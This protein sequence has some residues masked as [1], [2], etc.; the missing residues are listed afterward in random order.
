MALF[1]PRYAAGNTSLKLL[2]Y[3][4]SSFNPCYTRGENKHKNATYVRPTLQPPLRAGNTCDLKAFKTDVAFNPRYTTRGEYGVPVSH[5]N[6][7]DLQPPC[8]VMGNKV[9]C[10]YREWR[11]TGSPAGSTLLA[12]SQPPNRAA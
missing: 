6:G 8:V 11:F 5:I 1:N 9:A 12:G 10:V 3:K 4:L 2:S 7:A